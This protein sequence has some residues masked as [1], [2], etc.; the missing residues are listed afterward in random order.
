[1]AVS[2]SRSSLQVRVDGVGQRARKSMIAL[3][4]NSM[5]SSPGERGG[6]IGPRRRH[7]RSYSPDPM[8]SRGLAFIFPK[9][10]EGERAA[11]DEESEWQGESYG[12][13]VG[14]RH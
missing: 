12:S 9:A 7:R 14:S 2:W 3:S 8:M 11:R 4:R 1:M 5:S 13:M 6:P 10:E